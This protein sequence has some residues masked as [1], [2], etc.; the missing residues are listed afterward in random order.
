MSRR[1]LPARTRG[2]DDG[3]VSR[4]N[5]PSAPPPHVSERADARTSGGLLTGIGVC[6]L[7]SALGYAVS[8]V[9]TLASPMLVAILFGV[10]VGNVMPMQPVQRGLDFAAKKL[11]RAGI[12]LLGLQLPLRDI[13]GL[14]WGALALAV[15]VVA[16]GAA[17]G[18]WCGRALGLSPSLSTLTA[19]GFSICGAAAVAAADGVVEADDEEV[20]TSIGLVV[21]FGTLMIPLTVGASALGLDAR[22]AG[23]FAGASIHEVAQVVAAGGLIGGGAL[24]VAVIVKLARVLMLAPVMTLLALRRRRQL[25]AASV[26]GEVALPP[27]VPLFVLG[28][29]AAVVARTALPLDAPTLDVAKAAETVLLAAAMFALG[30]GVRWRTMATVGARPLVHAVA[31]TTV[32]TLVAG[33]GTWALV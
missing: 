21:L 33:C 23:F 2:H 22:T 30:T 4:T 18:L 20:A 8:R 13:I 1:W 19:C 9:S 14:G 31:C 15:T 27:L 12:V 16:V 10:V 6:L 24:G 26:S 5:V 32:V 7:A 28:F 25:R 17:F 29:I 3:G 11:L